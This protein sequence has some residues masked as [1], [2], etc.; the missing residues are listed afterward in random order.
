MKSRFFKKFGKMAAITVI[1]V[2]LFA[3]FTTGAFALN[4]SGSGGGTGNKAFNFQ[5]YEYNAGDDELYLYFD[6]QLNAITPQ[7]VAEHF[8]VVNLSTSS[9]VN[10]TFDVD[11]GTGYSGCSDTNLDRGTTVT[12]AFTTPLDEDTLY[13]V[14]MIA[15][16]MASNSGMTLGNYNYRNDITFIFRTPD[17]YGAY[18]GTP[19]FSFLPNITTDVPQEGN[20]AFA[21]DRPVI[22]S[23]DDFKDDLNDNF[24]KGQD[25]VVKDY[26][27]DSNPVTEAES[28]DARANDAGT[29][30]FFPLTGAGNNTICYNLAPD[31]TYS[32]TVPDFNYSGGSYTGAATYSFTTVENDIPAWI[33]NTP[34][35]DNATSSTLDVTWSDSTIP[36]GTTPAATE[37]DVYYSESEWAGFEKL[38]ID[39]ISAGSSP[40][41]FIAGDTGDNSEYE[42]V[43]ETMYYFRIVP[44]DDNGQE[45]GFSLAG[46]GT[47]E[48]ER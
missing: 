4:Y 8:S 41:T 25:I 35:V 26:T 21:V 38:N 37:Y 16:T 39:P 3:S 45:A 17:E 19:V 40:Y 43:P 18:S 1:A 7:I 22:S 27:I 32:I 46:S 13:E 33:N 42:L 34:I 24:K 36:D 29:F 2:M 5:G 47:T 10:F 44:L 15:S 12:L 31:S 14:T 23:I 28:Y 9:S 30:F 48:T 11:W 20:V 6:K